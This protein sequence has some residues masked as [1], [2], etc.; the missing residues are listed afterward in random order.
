[1]E[2]SAKFE[3]FLKVHLIIILALKGREGRVG[4]CQ[5]YD[6]LP[7]GTLRIRVLNI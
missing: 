5:P 7:Y 2:A 6:L 1:M 3:K 4:V